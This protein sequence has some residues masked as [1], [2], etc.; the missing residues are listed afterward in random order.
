MNLNDQTFLLRM[1]RH[2][3]FYKKLKKTEQIING[4][5]RG[6]GGGGILRKIGRSKLRE[7]NL[8]NQKESVWKIN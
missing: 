8:R 7:K 1:F 6:G 5:N 2:F 3:S 4:V